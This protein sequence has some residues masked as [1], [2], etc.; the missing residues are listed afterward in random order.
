MESI[1]YGTQYN[2]YVLLQ[3]PLIL[4]NTA[5]NKVING[6]LVKIEIFPDQIHFA[7]NTKAIVILDM[8]YR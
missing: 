1:L 4:M 6:V 7:K 5:I 3:Q 2:I 8:L